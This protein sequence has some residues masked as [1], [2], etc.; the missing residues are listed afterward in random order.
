[1]LGVAFDA[2]DDDLMDENF[3]HA[4]AEI[5]AGIFFDPEAVALP[6]GIGFEGAEGVEVAGVP[7]GLEIGKDGGGAFGEVW[8]FVIGQEGSDLGLDVGIFGGGVWGASFGDVVG[9]EGSLG[10]LGF[11]GE[12][13]DGLDRPIGGSWEEQGG[14]M[15]AAAEG[16]AFQ[17]ASAARAAEAIERLFCA[18]WGANFAEKFP[19]FLR[20]KALGPCGELEVAVEA[21]IDL[22]AEVW[23]GV[24]GGA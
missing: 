5:L 1:M 21:E 15:D 11:F 9:E 20:V 19:R 3:F 6:E 22:N 16:I 7:G 13:G 8:R 24:G 17:R 10:V 12:D 4:V 18:G 23:G 14:A 2:T